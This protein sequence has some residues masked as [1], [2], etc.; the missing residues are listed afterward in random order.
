[1]RINQQTGTQPF[2][3]PRPYAPKPAAE[4]GDFQKA[5]DSV[6]TTMQAADVKATDAMVGRG[7]I[8]TAMIAMTKADLGF[9]FLTQVRG[10]AVEA[11]RQ[12]M[13][14]QF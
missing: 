8:H 5:I 1:M 3:E 9:R 2:T 12:L 7:S 10:K 4:A 11:Y 14:L 6:R 13:N